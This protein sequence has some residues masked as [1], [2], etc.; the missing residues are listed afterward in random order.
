MKLLIISLLLLTFAGN[1]IASLLVTPTR[2]AFDVRDRTAEVVLLNTSNTQR[3]YRLEWE[4]Q[5]QGQGGGYVKLSEE[6]LIN[7]PRADKFIRFAPRSVTLQPGESQTVRLMVRRTADMNLAEYRSHLKFTALPNQAESSV[8]NT[9]QTTGV[10]IK[11]NVLMSYSIPIVLRTQA[12]NKSVNITEMDIVSREQDGKKVVNF[13]LAKNSQNSI[14]GDFTLF[15]EV[16]GDT[17]EL[18]YLNGVNMFAETNV[19]KS[20]IVLLRDIEPLT[21]NLK[22]VFKGK[23]EFADTVFGEAK[24]VLK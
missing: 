12:P 18:G 24:I 21:G 7:F 20:N 6:D 23:Q 5:A 16:E 13:T 15:H 1:A 14:F 9:E 22:L 3:S 10:N 2:V 8:E 11:L 4:N 17:Y 19:M